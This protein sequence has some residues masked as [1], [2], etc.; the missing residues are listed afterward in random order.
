[1]DLLFLGIP[2]Q[3]HQKHPSY[4]YDQLKILLTHRWLATILLTAFATYTQQQLASFEDYFVMVFFFFKMYSFNN[5]VSFSELILYMTDWD[6]H[7]CRLIFAPSR[8]FQTIS[9]TEQCKTHHK[10]G[11]IFNKGNFIMFFFQMHSCRS[12]KGKGAQV[13]SSFSL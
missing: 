6:I 3:N 1:M 7:I 12:D 13:I 5:I 9:S 8:I 4:L 11:F 10:K 2:S